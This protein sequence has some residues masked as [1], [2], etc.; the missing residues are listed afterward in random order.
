ML[1]K[2]KP[3]DQSVPNQQTQN[4]EGSEKD[5]LVEDIDCNCSTSPRD[6]D[7]VT[8]EC[9]DESSPSQNGR[10]LTLKFT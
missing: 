10:V 3:E 5:H 1:K 8:T 7:S 2:N 4:D 9:R 6:E